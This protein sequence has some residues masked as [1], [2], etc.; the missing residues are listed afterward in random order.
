MLPARKRIK[1]EDGEH[2]F[3]Q[4]EYDELWAHYY[5]E[6]VV[7]NVQLPSGRTLREQR[8]PPRIERDSPGFKRLRATLKELKHQGDHVRIF[9]LLSQLREWEICPQSLG[10]ATPRFMREGGEGGQAAVAEVVDLVDEVE[11]LDVDAFIS[12]VLLVGVTKVRSISA[13][14]RGR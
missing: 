7:K 5:D 14:V 3:E 1:T 2:A 6:V 10:G 12:E 9:Q 8:R 4:T 13:V 11:V